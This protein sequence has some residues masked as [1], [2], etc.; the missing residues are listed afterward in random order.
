[1]LIPKASHL[2][3]RVAERLQLYRDLEYMPLSPRGVWIDE[4]AECDCPPAGEQA[5]RPAGQTPTSQEERWL[6][7][8]LP[9]PARQP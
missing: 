6:P 4:V 9:G 7:S 1:M 3:E 5:K 8:P 2:V